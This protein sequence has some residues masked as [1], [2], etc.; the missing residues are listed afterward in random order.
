MNWAE[1]EGTCTFYA[2][3][4]Q[5]SVESH[6]R[7]MREGGAAR[8]TPNNIA[9]TAVTSGCVRGHITMSGSGATVAA[10]W[11]PEVRPL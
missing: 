10:E 7:K 2:M 4:K 8:L 3:A 5:A 6:P 11:T 9:G 1:A